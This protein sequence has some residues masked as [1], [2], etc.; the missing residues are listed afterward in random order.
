MLYKISIKYL[1]LFFN[2]R[3]ILC[4]YSLPKKGMPKTKQFVLGIFI[5]S[6]Q[7]LILK[8]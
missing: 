2:H 1:N 6:K 4:T 5:Q 8:V 3:L 7:M